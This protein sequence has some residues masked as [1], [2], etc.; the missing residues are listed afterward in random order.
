MSSRL[1]KRH[2]AAA[3]AA[4]AAREDVSDDSEDEHED[5]FRVYAGKNKAAFALLNEEGEESSED[6]G[7]D[8]DDSVPGEAAPAPIERDTETLLSNRERRELKR[9][10]Q[11]QQQ[12]QLESSS[13]NA[14]AP[15]HAKEHEPRPPPVQ[16]PKEAA[17]DPWQLNAL[18]VDVSNELSRMFGRD[19]LREA[20]AAERKERQRLAH[21]SDRARAATA[22]RLRAKG[23]G[24]GR[25]RMIKPRDNWPDVVSG[26]L[27]MDIDHEH[28]SNARSASSG[29]FGDLPDQFFV[30]TH[31]STYRQSQSALTEIVEMG[32]PRALQEFVA[33]H[34][35]QVD[36]LLR[37]SDYLAMIGQHELAAEHSERALYAMEQALHP[38]CKLLEGNARVRFA[39]PRNQPFFRALHRHMISAGRRGCH[40]TALELGRLLL[41]L[42]PLADPMHAL[43]H[44]DHHA[45]RAADDAEEA[46]RWLLA[47]PAALPDHS[48]PLYPNFAFSLALARRRLFERHQRRDRRLDESADEQ[49]AAAT[50][51][52][53]A[54]GEARAQLR[55]ALLLFPAALPLLVAAAGDAASEALARSPALLATWASVHGEAASEA[56]CGATLRKLL[57]LYVRKSASLWAVRGTCTWLIDEAAVITDALE[58]ATRDAS[59]AADGD[60]GEGRGDAERL[61][62]VRL[63]HDARAA[64]EDQYPA[65][66]AKY[67]EFG[68][69]DPADFSSAPPDPLP[70][71]QLEQAFREIAAAGGGGGGRGG[72]GGANADDDGGWAA[73][74]RPEGRLVVPRHEWVELDPATHPLKQF[75]LSLLPWTVAPARRW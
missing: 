36:G 38:M 22:A 16:K 17:I 14:V 57:S 68:S 67:D 56:R 6:D 28:G 53:H 75:F 4:A 55:R 2:V 58:V 50:A 47:L 45:L 7:N 11:Q 33:A 1:V 74:I 59:R 43:L 27:G 40:R 41:S 72:G 15:A 54:E 23:G 37:L 39:E 32:D 31:S 20:N 35:W 63:W 64:R 8:S 44:L 70:A 21:G 48:L 42:D 5:D 65:E 62:I 69:A 51:E 26:G 49:A 30:F 13:D 71:E 3:A 9:Q 10:Q 24:G 18:H 25:A 52:A 29:R 66:T 34:P 60:I 12:Q 73:R 46:T 61:A 19:A